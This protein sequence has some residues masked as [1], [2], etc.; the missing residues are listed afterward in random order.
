MVLRWR[1]DSEGGIRGKSTGGGGG[2]TEEGGD[3]TGEGKSNLNWGLPPPLVPILSY[4]LSSL[5][6]PLQQQQIESKHL[7][8]SHWSDLWRSRPSLVAG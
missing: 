4:W 5:H 6:W 1:G 3:L 2:L 8:G 7:Q